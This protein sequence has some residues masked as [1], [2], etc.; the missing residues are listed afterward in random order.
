[1]EVDTN[2]MQTKP[3]K[4]TQKNKTDQ[5]KLCRGFGHPLRGWLF[6]HQGKAAV[7]TY[8]GHPWAGMLSA[9]TLPPLL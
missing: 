7:A 1:M 5:T 9:Q 2:P 8:R 3:I 6:S 4:A